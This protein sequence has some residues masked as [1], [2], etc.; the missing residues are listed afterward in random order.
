MLQTEMVGDNFRLGFRFQ[1]HW[2]VSMAS[3]FYCGELGSGLFLVS[4]IYSFVAGLVLGLLITGVG[5]SLFHLAHMGVPGKSWRAILRPDRSWISRGLVAIVGFCGAGTLHTIDV[6]LGVASPLAGAI[7]LIAGAAA[8][9]VMSYQ[10]FAMGHSSAIALWNTAIMPVASLL[11][12]LTG[13]VILILML[14]G[15]SLAPHSVNH[16]VAMSFGLLLADVIMLVCMLHIA[17]HGSPGSRLSAQL[18]ISTLYAKWF[19]GLVIGAGILLPMLVLWLG[20]ESLGARA[21]AAAGVLAGFYA[22]RVL[23]FKAGVYDPVMT[24]I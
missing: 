22:F 20:H 15:G 9:V 23:I 19:H 3:A 24:F 4:M 21:I 8:L 11:Y 14:H 2:D 12:A 6:I 13:G 17:Y 10:G 5:K 16:L 7:E 1:R 18:L